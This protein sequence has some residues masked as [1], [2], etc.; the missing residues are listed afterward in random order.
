VDLP[1]RGFQLHKADA[2]DNAE[3]GGA[4][5]PRQRAKADQSA[6]QVRLDSQTTVGESVVQQPQGF[7]GFRNLKMGKCFRIQRWT[8]ETNK[9]SIRT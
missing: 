2:A 3:G 9:E 4:E 5:T 7:M 1:R 6:Q 8:Q